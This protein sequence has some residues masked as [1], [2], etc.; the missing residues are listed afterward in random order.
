MPNDHQFTVAEEDLASLKA[1]QK[2]IRDNLD[3]Q[4]LPLEVLMPIALR[5]LNAH[6][7]ANEALA[8]ITGKDFVLLPTEANG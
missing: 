3:G 1:A 5:S 4:D 8:A 7:L 6:L 2:L